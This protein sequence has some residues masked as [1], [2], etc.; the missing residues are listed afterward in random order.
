MFDPDFKIADRDPHNYAVAAITF[1]ELM[2]HQTKQAICIA[3]ESGAGKT[4]NAKQ[5]MQFLTQLGNVKV[6]S[7]GR[8]E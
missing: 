6:H 2:D 4:E 5:C 8:V 1:K 3:G 7:D